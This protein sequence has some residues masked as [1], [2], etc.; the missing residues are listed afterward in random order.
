MYI[1]RT[2]V[3][4]FC[5]TFIGTILTKGRFHLRT[6]DG[7]KRK[8]RERSRR[9]LQ[10][11]GKTEEQQ[12]PDLICQY[13]EECT[14]SL[15]APGFYACRPLTNNPLFPQPVPLLV[16]VSLSVCVP[17]NRLPGD[18][19]G[20]CAGG[21][22]EPTACPCM[23]GEDSYYLYL[24]LFGN[25]IGYSF[26]ATLSLANILLALDPA[27]FQCYPENMLDQNG[28]ATCPTDLAPTTAC[29]CPCGSDAVPGVSQ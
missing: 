8:R 28:Q 17:L 7:T 16:D 5:L 11:V 15:G 2:I 6:N 23:C 18:E 26:C 3:T 29:S 24:P 4:L 20:C 13:R 25:R 21:C 9:E 12:Q 10:E 22:P 27:F 1:K 14:D 19:C